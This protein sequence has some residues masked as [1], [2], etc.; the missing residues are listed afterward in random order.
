[1]GK[2]GKWKSL[3]AHLYKMVVENLLGVPIGYNELIIFSIELHSNLPF[4]V[5][6]S[7]F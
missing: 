6:Q 4:L 7:S 5:V 3:I 2:K 1:M